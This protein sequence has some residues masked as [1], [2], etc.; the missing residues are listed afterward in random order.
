MDPPQLPPIVQQLRDLNIPFNLNVVEREYSI[1]VSSTG[2]LTTNV[3]QEQQSTYFVDKNRKKEA[4]ATSAKNWNKKK[5]PG[6]EQKTSGASTSEGISGDMTSRQLRGNQ[7]GNCM[8][9]KSDT[10][11]DVLTLDDV[12]C[13]SSCSTITSDDEKNFNP[14]KFEHLR[15]MKQKLHK[16]EKLR[17]LSTQTCPEK[18]GDYW[19]QNAGPAPKE[20]FNQK[21]EQPIVKTTKK[22]KKIQSTKKIF[23]M[24]TRQQT[25]AQKCVVTKKMK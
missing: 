25:K 5:R 18:R 17:R 6:D 12:E 4:P 16:Q 13:G 21:C 22:Q 9:I 19:Q 24:K 10:K 23:S 20:T 14:Q 11:A 8:G 7:C 3:T 15:T 2:T 1:E